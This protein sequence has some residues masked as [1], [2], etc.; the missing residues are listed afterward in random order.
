MAE[1][2]K[3]KDFFKDDK[4][5]MDMGIE[6]LKADAEESVCAFSVTPSHFNAGGSVQGGAIFTLADF[7][8]AVAANCE[9]SRTVSQSASVTFIKP[10]I[11]KRLYATAKRISSGKRTC[12]YS[13]FVTNEDEMLIA[14]ITVNGFIVE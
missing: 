1:L 5:A 11:G 7:T 4:F 12:H 3:V 13:V 9:G 2:E 6:I 14:H 8:F 10:G